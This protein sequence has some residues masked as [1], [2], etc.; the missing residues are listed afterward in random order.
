MAYEGGCFC[1]AVRFSAS[2]VPLNER[3]CHCRA[4][5]KVIGAAF[6]ARILFRADDVTV[7]GELVRFASSPGLD[8]GFCS[9]CGATVLS[10]RPGAGVIGLTAGSL[11]DPTVFRPAMHIWTSSRQPWLALNDGLP[12]HPGAAPS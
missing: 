1:G 3:V 7:T 10:A 8:R 2:N 6:N 12:Q 5:Q 9:K 11:D 4:C